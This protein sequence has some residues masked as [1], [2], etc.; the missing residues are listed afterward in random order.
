M[1]C[2]LVLILLELF[3]ACFLFL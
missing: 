2:K 1:A 3:F